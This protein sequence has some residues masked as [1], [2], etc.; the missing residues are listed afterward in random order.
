MENCFEGKTIPPLFMYFLLISPCSDMYK[1][2]WNK[3]AEITD[4][5]SQ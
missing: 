5:L 4:L 2:V 3:Q 1:L